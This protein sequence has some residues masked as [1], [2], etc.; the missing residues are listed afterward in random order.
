MMQELVQA[1]EDTV[2][3]KINELHTALPGTIKTYNAKTGTID[4][5]PSGVYTAANGEIYDYP[6]LTD[7][8]IVVTGSAKISIAA[9]IKSGDS[10]LLIFAEQSL[11]TWLSES[12]DDNELRFDLTNAIAIPGLTKVP[13][14]AQNEANKQNAIVVTGDFIVK[15]NVI[16]EGNIRSQGV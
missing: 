15:G 4:V 10:C 12:D 14:T 9:P 7:V 13:V 8:P 16:V 1:I 11:E 5:Q 3:E 6:L 2:A